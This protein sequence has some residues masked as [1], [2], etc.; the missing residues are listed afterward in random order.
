[1]V[2]GDETSLAVAASLTRAKP[3]RVVTTLLEAGAVDEVK[4]VARAL[5]LTHATVLPRGDL[6]GLS[7]TLTAQ[8]ELGA[9]PVFTGNAL[10]IQTL[11][12]F[13]RDAGGKT[14]AYWA[15]GKR[16]LD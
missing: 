9:T 2:I 10:T 8:L 16:G 14:K 1:V 15:A 3:G 11:K 4:D 6:E 5:E 7:K 13:R 12:K